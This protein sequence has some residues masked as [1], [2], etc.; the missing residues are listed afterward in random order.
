MDFDVADSDFNIPAPLDSGN[1]YFIYDTD[2]DNS[3][4]DETPQSMTDQGSNLW[5]VTVDFGSGGLFTL[6]STQNPAIVSLSPADNSTSASS[7]TN[8][9]IQ[10][11][12]SV[13]VDTGSI[14]IHKTSDDST[15]E[16][17]SVGSG[18][19]TGS[20]TDTITIN[21]A[22]NLTGGVEYYVLIPSTAFKNGSNYFGGISTT[23]GWSFTVAD[24]SAPTFTN[25]SA[26]TASNTTATVS[27]TTNEA[28]STR[29]SYGLTTAYGT[30]TSET[31]TSPRVTSHSVNLSSLLACTTY[32]YQ[33]LSTDGASNVGT[34][35]DQTFTTPGCQSDATPEST[36]SE[37]ITV[38]SGGTTTLTQ[39]NTQLSVEAPA[40]VTNAASSI[41]IQ[42]KALP[43]TSILSALGRPTAVPKEIGDIVFDV[44]AIINSTTILDSF[45]SPITI[46]YQYTDADVSGKKE[47]TFWLY[48]YHN[49]AWTALDD[50]TVTMSTNTISCSTDSFSVFGLF[51]QQE[52]ASAAVAGSGLGECSAIKPSGTSDV[53]QINTSSN[54]ATIFFTPLHSGVTNYYVAYGYKEG[55][56]R[57]GTFTGLGPSSGV[58]TY[59]INELDP[60]TTY[61]FKIRPQNGCAPGEWSN[62]MKATTVKKNASAAKH[63]KNI[64]ARVYSYLPRETADVHSVNVMG[65][66]TKVKPSKAKTQVPSKKMT[67]SC[68]Y[69]V[70][71]N[72]NLWKI[73][74]KKLGDGARYTEIMQENNFVDPVVNPGMKLKIGC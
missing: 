23:A 3:L 74:Q 51:G 13:T 47:S 18:Q 30:T 1:Y 17:I 25:I 52:T 4:T 26:S 67:A 36:K 10:F 41:V 72:E 70:Q 31:D 69:V 8:L 15:V 33:V 6:A 14:T 29:V 2:N 43:N 64:I 12:Q 22:N 16:T 5:R 57:F 28:A 62:S 54:K 11:S 50:C 46:T 37:S 38:S 48:H 9:V 40:N 63:Y 55:E 7:S 32:H 42:I 21:P 58:L 73:A 24:S 68:D 53:F 71:V 66:N 20:G 65:A 35:S 27:W 49:G 45:D 34:S 44:K 61:Y 19:V 59:T 56:E 39:S 60:N